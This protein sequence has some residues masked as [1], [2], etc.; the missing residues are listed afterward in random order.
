MNQAGKIFTK[1]IAN[2]VG[3]LKIL[4]CDNLDSRHLMFRNMFL[5][6]VESTK[7]L[8]ASALVGILI[9]AII[10]AHDIYRFYQMMMDG[11][12][13]QDQ[14]IELLVERLV[15]AL[16]AQMGSLSG[17][18]VGGM[19][20]YLIGGILGNIFGKV[21]GKIATGYVIKFG[22]SVVHFFENLI[23]ELKKGVGG[24]LPGANHFHND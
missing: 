18:C 7:V 13:D 1:S 21:F 2:S 19:P 5:G 16:C 15:M 9:E 3:L 22:A 14:F 4:K 6:M 8:A 12:I 10:N 11:R 24:F 20:G 17:F 23:Q